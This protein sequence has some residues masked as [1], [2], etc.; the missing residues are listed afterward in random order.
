MNLYSD[1]DITDPRVQGLS[2]ESTHVRHDLVVLMTQLLHAD[3]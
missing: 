2:V 1:P 3:A